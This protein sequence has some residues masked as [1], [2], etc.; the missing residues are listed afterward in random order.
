M[1]F[2]GPLCLFGPPCGSLHLEPDRWRTRG[3]R[4]GL[5]T[6]HRTHCMIEVLRRSRGH[7]GPSDL[8]TVGLRRPK[9]PSSAS[10][11]VQRG[12]KA[13][14]HLPGGQDAPRPREGDPDAAPT[15]SLRVGV[16]RSVVLGFFHHLL[17]HNP[18]IVTIFGP[19][20]SMIYFTPDQESSRF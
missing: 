15:A 16:G 5:P 4:H 11:G 17:P 13:L 3:R 19:C 9:P 1:I 14:M 6:R 12:G 18:K 10:L 20:E 8:V 2:F 7:D